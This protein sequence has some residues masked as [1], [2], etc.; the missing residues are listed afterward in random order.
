MLVSRLVFAMKHITPFAMLA[1]FVAAQLMSASLLA[2][3][4][5]VDQPGEVSEEDQRAAEAA[6][7]MEAELGKYKDTTP[8]AADLM[9]QLVDFYHQHGQ[10]F[11]LTRIGQRFI[12]IHTTDPRHQAVMLKLIDGLEVAARNK[13]LVATIRQFLQRY[14]DAPPAADLEI[15][16]AATL[17]ELMDYDGAGDAHR[18]VWKRAGA[19]ELGLKHALKSVTVYTY[20][21]NKEVFTKAAD[22]ASD[23]IEKLPDGPLPREMVSVALL[24]YQRGSEWAKANRAAA[25]AIARG[26]QLP[27]DKRRWLHYAM[28]ENFNRLGQYANAV[29]AFRKARAEKDGLDVHQALLQALAN[30]ASSEPNDLAPLVEEF[31]QKYPDRRERFAMQSLLAYKYRA[32]NQQPQAQAAFARL[33]DYDARS[34]SHAYYYLEQTKNEP[35]DNAAAEQVLLAAIEKNPDAGDKA[36]LRDVLGIMLYRDRMKDLGK[37]RPVCR[38]IVKQPFAGDARVQTALDLLLVNATSDAEF[39]QD[40]ALALDSMKKNLHHA[41]WRNY[42]VAWGKAYLKDEKLK[43]R[44]EYAVAQGEKWENDPVHKTYAASEAWSN[45]SQAAREQLIKT[46]QVAELSDAAAGPLLWRNAYFLR[47]YAAGERRPECVAAFGALVKRFPKDFDYAWEYLTAATDYGPKEASKEA[48]LHFLQFDPKANNHEVFRRLFVAVDQNADADLARQALAWMQQAEKTFGLSYGYAHYVGDILLKLNLK[49]EAIE[50]WKSHMDVDINV[51][52]AANCSDR[53]LAQ[54]PEGPERAQ[55]LQTRFALESDYHGYYA[56]QLAD[57]AFKADD[58][59]KFQQILTTTRERQAQRPLRN[60][61]LGEQPARSWVDQVRADMKASPE[62]KRLVYTL[63]KDLNLGRPSAMATLSLWAEFP[64]TAAKEPM[65]RLREIVGVT[66]LV[67][68]STYDWDTLMPYVQAALSRKDYLFAA[69]L[70]GG[71]LSNIPNLDPSRQQAGRAIVAQSYS[72]LGAV[73]LTIDE[74][75]EL[76]PLMQAALYLR[77]GDRTMALESYSANKALFD[78]HREEVPFDLLLFVC[79][80]LIA[81]GGD[82]NHD[83]VEEVLRGWLVKNSE[84]PQFD[85][86]MKASVQLLLAKNFDRARR[87]DI[88]RSEYATILNR[89]AD[90]PQAIEAEFGIGEAFMAQKVYDQAE[91]VFEKLAVSR[92]LDI[93]V[94]AEFLRGVLAYRRGDKDEARTI[95]KNVLDRVPN[96]ELANQALFNLAEVYKDEER[97]IDQLNLLR[98]VGRLGRRSKRTHAPGIPLS[99]V[100][101]DS[102]LGISRGH[103]RIP[104]IVTTQPGGDQERLFLTS[105]GAGKGLF[106]ADLDTR[107]GQVAKGDGVLQLSGKDTIQCDYPEEFKQEF[108]SVPLSDVEI[109]VASDGRLRMSSSK[110]ID[111]KEETFSQRLERE[112]RERQ[113]DLRVSQTRPYFQIKPGNPVYL[114]VDDAD[115][116]LSDAVDEVVVK[117]TAESGDTV[118]VHLKETG[119]HT[120]IFEGTSASAELPAGALAKDMALEHPPVLA[121]DQDPASHWMSEPDG[122]VP[123]WLSVDMKDLKPVSRV[124]IASPRKDRNIPVRG[125]LLGSYDGQFWFRLA[126]QPTPPPAPPALEKLGRMQLRVYAGNY[127]YFSNWNQIVELSKNAKPIETKEVDTLAWQLPADAANATA[128]YAVLWDGKLVQEKAGATRIFVNGNCTALWIDGQLELAVGQSPRSVDLWLERGT[129]DL[130]IFSATGNG[131]QGVAAVIAR[132]DANAATVTMYPFRAADFDLDDK[133]LKPAR[134]APPARGDFARGEWM[135]AFEPRELRH[136]KFV[137]NEY[138]GEAVAVSTFEIAGEDEADVYIP[139]ADDVLTLS[140]NQTLEIAGGDVITGSYTDEATHQD[141]EGSRLLTEKLTATYFNASVQAIQYEFL[142]DRAGNVQEI[143]KQVMR[144]AP[145][146]RFIVEIIDYDL[147]QSAEHDTA[148]FDVIVNDG[149]PV[150]FVAME[151]EAYT[152][153]FRKEIDTSATEEEGKVTIEPGDRIYVRYIDS[154]NTFPGHAVPREA[155]VYANTPSAGRIRILETRVIPGDKQRGVPP[156]FIYHTPPRTQKTS[157]VAF[158]APLTVE[159]IDP[160]AARDSRSE[161]VVNLST[162][163]GSTVDVRCVVSGAFEQNSQGL[164]YGV[165]DSLALQ[166]GRF[167]GQVIMQLG[168]KNSPQEVPVGADMPRNLVGGTVSESGKNGV[169]DVSLVT[170]VLNLT[171]QDTINA[172][173]A[174]EQTLKTSPKK[175][176]AQARLISNGKLRSTDRDYEKDVTDLHVGEKLFLM[177]NDPDQDRTDERDFVSVELST[178]MGDKEHVRLYETL[179]HSGVFTGSLTMKSSTEPQT[180]NYDEDDPAIE[181]YF[182]DTVTMTYHDPAA[183]TEQGTLDSIVEAPVVIGTDGLVAA[184]TKTFNNEQLAV[185]TK[186]TIAESYFELFKSHKQLGRKSEQKADLESGRRV[187]REVMEDYPDPKYVPRIAYLLGQFS[188]ELGDWDEAVSA[189]RLIIDQY[190]DHQLAPDAQYKMAQAYEE[191]G[192]FDAALEAYVTLAATYPKSPLIASVMIRICDHFYKAEEFQIAAQVGEKFIEKF[193]GHQHASRIAFRIGQCFYKAEAFA[194]AGKAFDRFAKEFPDDTLTP[195]SVF[196]SGESYRKGNNISEA[197]RRY[198]RCRWDYPASEAAKFARG[199]LAL[200]EMLQQFESEANSVENP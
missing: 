70:A 133:S 2:Q 29:D 131:T 79:E 132:A 59:A 85:P 80:S 87:Y 72:R 113:Q 90:T 93:V 168:G 41:N 43:A 4:K 102:D 6:A 23:L 48:A 47:H 33:L 61:G 27:P 103:S 161:V 111:E 77:L 154:Q 42:L 123:K 197:F 120:G 35:A 179:A 9:V 114:R 147:D 28:G 153:R 25:T 178:A 136:V 109:R 49:P 105:G 60:W 171:G 152:G 169:N 157:H 24:Q 78:T 12:S 15:R 73:G 149:P 125:D 190:P 75:S 164:P 199:R 94:R 21:N 5:A 159:V 31:Q 146:D 55:F 142:R 56:G 184:F 198:N 170:R 71:M 44:A 46:G 37:A 183:S 127:T 195:D 66:R 81:V 84:N 134:I 65:S 34:G 151:T 17:E 13:E 10:V 175:L 95:F 36:Y 14:P 185:E 68:N 100:V 176:K 187:L 163:A 177:V 140:T 91:A 129:H 141:R 124:R 8:E 98:T 86:S 39:Q 144:V 200:P 128:P 110:I 173:Y 172:A 40:V 106:R 130:T 89:Y 3:T 117:L 160:D 135:F 53:L 63:V 83:Y 156:Q 167:I 50:V 145:G 88:A 58:M 107:L 182:G 192:D 69:T 112:T 196:W 194:E 45:E 30:D 139:T 189:Y 26:V 74:R 166:E 52:D 137:I 181:V 51:G 116:D 188:Q 76:A 18:A 22:L 115:R 64:E 155:V 118:Q 162:P 101:Q 143:P 32:K 54:L 57:L 122:A 174:D 92:N 62:K 108:K 20:V 11:G 186:F 38:E 16:L 119:S 180:G 104:V 19:T 126:S 165:A 150:E 138:V 97:F 67:D 99:I 1:A 7:R 158:E 191:R 96:I 121:I 82:N 148:K 193:D